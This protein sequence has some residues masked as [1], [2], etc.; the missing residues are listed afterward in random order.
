MLKNKVNY[1][2]KFK[3]DFFSSGLIVLEADIRQVETVER[4]KTT[5][6]QKQFNILRRERVENRLSSKIDKGLSKENKIL[7]IYTKL[8]EYGYNKPFSVFK[9]QLITKDLTLKYA[10]TK[11]VIKLIAKGEQRQLLIKYLD[12][13][14]WDS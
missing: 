13:D 4:V 7:K 5:S 9:V 11:K 1:S 8:C 10:A 2:V 3:P 14:L 12:L 6:S